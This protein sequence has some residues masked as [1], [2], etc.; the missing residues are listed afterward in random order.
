MHFS[1]QY[2]RHALDAARSLSLG[3]SIYF[4]SL[5]KNTYGYYTQIG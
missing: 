1:S 3:F 2:A 4:A 5:E